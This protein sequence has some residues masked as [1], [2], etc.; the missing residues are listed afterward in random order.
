MSLSNQELQLRFASLT[1]PLVA[2]ACM[3]LQRICR[4]APGIWPLLPGPPLCG[5]ALPVRH[6][7]SVDVFLEA[8]EGAAYGDV[9]VID[10]DGRS[11]EGCIG[12]LTALEAQ[13]A[14]LAGIVVWGAVRDVAELA[15]IGLPIYCRGRCPLGPA[16]LRPRAG[17]HHEVCIGPVVVTRE[18]VV[19]ADGNGVLFVAAADAAEVLDQAEAI[20]RRERDQAQRARAGRSLREQFQFREFLAER[21]RNPAYTLREHLQRLGAAIEV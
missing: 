16:G 2:D 7:G 10:N 3:T 1:T 21:A 11:D 4:F 14:G 20:A 12:D 6:F 9:L 15:Q 13:G 8:F 5:R 18:D 19:I 17:S